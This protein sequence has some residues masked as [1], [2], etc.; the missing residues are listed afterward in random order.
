M[1]IKSRDC[2]T[3]LCLKTSAVLIGVASSFASSL[4]L[5]ATDPWGY[6]E[7]ADKGAIA[8]I[9]PCNQDRQSLCAKLLWIKDDPDGTLLDS[10]NTDALLQQ[11][12][13]TGLVFVDGVAFKKAGKWSGGSIYDPKSGKSYKAKVELKSADKIKLGGCIAF[14]CDSETWSRTSKPLQTKE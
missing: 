1:Y 7:A 12:K 2:V 9:Y 6:W 4:S 11:R 13:L 8:E 5:A 14:L 3:G 10:N